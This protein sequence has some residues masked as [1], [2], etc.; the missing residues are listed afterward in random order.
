[1]TPSRITPSH[2]PQGDELSSSLRSV[3]K[4][5]DKT[6]AESTH[7]SHTKTGGDQNQD[8]K[9][10]P[11]KYTL[12]VGY[13]ALAATLIAASLWLKQALQL[14]P[15]R[16]SGSPFETSLGT[17]PAPDFSVQALYLPPPWRE[18][19]PLTRRLGDGSS[20]NLKHLTGGG[21][22]AVVVNFWASWCT[23]CAD[24]APL[25][26]ALW[27]EFGPDDLTVVG[28]VLHDDPVRATEYARSSGKKFLLGYDSRGR[29]A[30]DYGVTGV[31]ETIFI[32]R[33][34][35][36]YTKITGP[37]DPGQLGAIIQGLG[38]TGHS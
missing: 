32:N 20:L 15:L 22:R 3:H 7:T 13:L 24:E 1:M 38:L 33:D 34:Q 31:P 30:I 17:L 16:G 36:V 5:V 4:T 12:L 23:T 19:H 35:K 26:N 8:R 10:H 25:L 9:D 18:L 27:S 29:V 14:N 2:K 11:K 21:E 6:T 28:V 37:I